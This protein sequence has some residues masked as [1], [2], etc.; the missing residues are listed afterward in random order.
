MKELIIKPEKGWI[1]LDFRELWI[2]RELI[3]FFVWREIKV[4][5]KQ[6]L[7]GIMWVVFQ[8]LIMMV[9]FSV[10]FGKFAKM[11]SE[12]IP[13]P[14]FVYVGLLFWNYFSFGLSKTSE[15]IVSNA[16]VIQKVYFPRLIIPISSSLTP[17]ID[18]CVA[19]F[20]LGC[21]MAY[22][23][24]VPSL[25][26]LLYVPLLLIVTFLSSVGI[27]CF[28][29]SINAKY[30]DIRYIMPFFIQTLLFLT[31]V[32]Y[33][34]SIATEKFRYLFAINPMSGVIEIARA[35]ILQAKPCDW[36]FFLLSVLSMAIFLTAGLMYFKNTERFFADFI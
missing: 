28:I 10:F 34:S 16:T 8:P 3:F 15:S 6:T 25:T 2:Y 17:L 36:N 21:L 30:R 29:A 12:G 20:I 11:P 33:P 27:G 5:Y 13:Y 35:V 18:F 23:G 31:P 7:L 26:G 1:P 22:Y 4:R 9:I 24:Y 19:F 14:V 32:I